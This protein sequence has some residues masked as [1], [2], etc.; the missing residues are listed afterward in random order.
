MGVDTT[1]AV[2]LYLALMGACLA[3]FVLGPTPACA[4]T[5]LAAAHAFVSRDACELVARAARAAG[6]AAG[7]AAARGAG[8]A[9]ARYAPLGVQAVY[10]ALVGV[11]YHVFASHVIDELEGSLAVHRAVGPAVVAASVGTFAAVCLARA[12]EV[13]ATN[14]ELYLAAYDYDGCLFVAGERCP[15]ACNTQRVQRPARS[16]YV[17]SAGA[18]VPRFDHVCPWI[19]GPVGEGNYRWFLLFLATHTA[20]CAYGSAVMLLVLA[21]A[22]DSR[23]V[24]AT[25]FTSATGAPVHPN[26]SLAARWAVAFYPGAMFLFVLLVLVTLMLAC[27]TGYHLYLAA[28]NQTSYETAKRAVMLQDAVDVALYEEPERAA[29]AAAGERGSNGGPA[30][31]EAGGDG[32]AGCWRRLRARRVATRRV[33]DR[34]L[35]RGGADAALA[36]NAYDRGLLANLA[37]ALVPELTVHARARAA[38]ARH[39]AQ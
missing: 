26:A 1:T 35:A 19:N 38:V 10:V 21:D 5:P 16:K 2:A 33:C 25:T 32:I 28:T 20:L 11:G 7:E 4:G 12:G 8:R 3:V 31:A 30:A 13:D 6:G 9:V 29:Q 17:R 22:V 34:A 23:G 37:E 14:V 24:M 27:F 39:K 18:L 15:A 36:Y